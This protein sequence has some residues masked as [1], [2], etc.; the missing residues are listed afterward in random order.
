MNITDTRDVVNY[1]NDNFKGN[2]FKTPTEGAKG[3]YDFLKNM[4]V[5]NGGKADQVSLL[6]IE[7]EDGFSYRVSWEDGPYQW[8]IGACY[9]VCRST[10]D[11]FTEPQHSFDLDFVY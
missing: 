4:V 7:K 3:F 6:K 10:G 2:S 9:S 8:A 1:I 5:A 11:W